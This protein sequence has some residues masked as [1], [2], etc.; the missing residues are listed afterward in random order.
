[1]VES[2]FVMAIKKR[3]THFLELLNFIILLGSCRG[4][5]FL[6]H[7]FTFFELPFFR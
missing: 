3:K 2:E 4:E 5:G 7:E 1:M 6:L